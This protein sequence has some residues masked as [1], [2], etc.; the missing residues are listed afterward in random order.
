M[1]WFV[2][3]KAGLRQIAERLVERRGFG[4]LL[5]ELY[6]NIMDTDATEGIVSLVKVPNRPL[7]KLSVVDNST[8]GFVDLTHAWTVFAP[9]AKKDDP[10]KA[11]RFNLGEKVVLAFCDE[12]SIET[13]S[14]TV[15]FKDNERNVYPRRKRPQG[16]EFTAVI[17][18]TQEHYDQFLEYAK[19]LLIKPGFTF[20][21]NG[22]TIPSR[23][24]FHTFETKLATEV[25]ETLRRTIRTTQV[26]IVET[27]GSPAMLYE[28]GIPVVETGD[29]WH[30]NVHQKVPLNVDRD[31][32]TPAYLATLRTAVFN[33]TF[34]LV[35]ADDTT[36]NWVNDA[37]GS[38]QCN[39]EALEHFRSLKFGLNSVAHDPTNQEANAEAVSHGYTV[40]PPRGLT[41]DQRRNL[42]N[43][44]LLQTSSQAFPDAG[45]NAYSNS[46]G[47]KPVE[48]LSGDAL[49]EGMKQIKEYTEGMAQR[50]MGKRIDVQFVKTKSVVSSWDACYGRGHLFGTPFFHYNVSNLGKPWFERGANLSVDDLIIHEFGHEYES[51]HL[52]EKYYNALTRLAAKLKVAALKEPAWFL[53]FMKEKS[54]DFTI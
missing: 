10:T 37:T 41:P 31:N 34:N 29:K 35:D 4:I 6:Q 23:T 15:V 53:S 8:T 28:L 3:H 2:A 49:T 26:D 46:P 17:S 7:A 13:T 14:G 25:G 30:V 45:R 21:V 9:S 47:A 38:E 36:S 42:Y 27:N 51:N 19:T 33:E 18:C 48:V 39:P 12:A 40:I 44:N 5:A 54:S 32:V 22:Q 1:D 16:T 52:S 43:H 20:T 11:G 24:P 50:L